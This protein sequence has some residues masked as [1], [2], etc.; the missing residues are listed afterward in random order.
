MANAIPRAN[1]SQAEVLTER[2]FHWQF[3]VNEWLVPGP[4]LLSHADDEGSDRWTGPT[5]ES[6]H[7]NGWF[8]EP[9]TICEQ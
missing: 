6:L 2:E 7:A 8:L 1:W 9:E 4:A 3:V 5:A